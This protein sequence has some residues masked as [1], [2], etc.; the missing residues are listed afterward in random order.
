[1]PGPA[2]STPERASAVHVAI[3]TAVAKQNFVTAGRSMQRRALRTGM[4]R[5]V[6]MRPPSGGV[7]IARSRVANGSLTATR[8][9]VDTGA[10]GRDPPG[11]GEVIPVVERQDFRLLGPL[12]VTRDGRTLEL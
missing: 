8:R 11:N 3:A 10:R 2:G 12:E 5:L 9:L 6:A 4:W 1:M 7:Q